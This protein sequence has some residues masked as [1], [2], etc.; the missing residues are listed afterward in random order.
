M[1][2][3]DA[4][5]PGDDEA[6]APLGRTLA[7]ARPA[8]GRMCLATLLGSGAV[9][10]SIGLIATAAWLISRASQHPPEASLAVAIVA[11]Q[12]FGLSRGFFRYGER[13]V[14]HDAAFH[15][16]A[17]LRVGIYRD[18]ES[19]APAGLPAF[20][21]GDLLARLVGD[22]DTLQDVVLRVIPPFAIAALVGGATVAFVWSLLPAAGAV[23]L[24]A[25]LLGCTV[26]P[27]AT[28]RKAR[29]SEARQAG[30]RGELGAASVDLIEGAAD[31]VV[32]GAMDA[33]VARIAS[34]DEQL[35]GMATRSAGTAG[36]GAALTM[37]LAGLAMW[38]A[39]LVGIP[40][41]HAGRLDGVLLAVITLVPLAAFELVAGIPPAMQSLERARGAA[42]RVF[43]VAD[44]PA[45]V[46]DPASPA[47]LPD[48]PYDLQTRGLGSS[49][50]GARAPALED[51]S[52]SLRPGSRVALV[53]PSGAGKTTLAHVVLRFLP[54]TGS[55]TLSGTELSALGGDDARRVV[56]MVGQDAHVF[57]TT[58]A[59]NL[60]I[61]RRDA[62]DEELARVVTAVGL[63]DWVGGLP[64]GLATDAGERGGRMSGGQ[65][66]RLAVAR[67]L[68][69]DFPILVL[70]EPT[71]HLDRNAA[72]A[73]GRDLVALTAGRSTLLITHRL[74]GL[75]DL[76]EVF[77]LDGGRVIEHG[78]HRELVAAGG[79]YAELW[80]EERQT[81]QSL[82]VR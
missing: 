61:G 26:V 29:R 49:Y 32:F 68:L 9:A 31:L 7:V 25:L 46:A 30:V 80:A 44:S 47:D 64:D 20:R 63:A 35:A 8:A 78:T 65:R 36:V 69:A 11:V 10:A 62:G 18:L 15:L 75:H 40:A 33:Q 45:P 57:A 43:A 19:L 24:V 48:A 2:R 5:V 52:L 82:P 23:L 76:D 70:D 22:V 27:A 72:D 58:L 74:S 67:A 4:R 77:V 59:E 42:A 38:G 55:A 81:G 12:F 3:G 53:G 66:Q 28:G 16:L 13:I 1:S 60:R 14:G 41:V 17:D 51:V 71:E 73:L 39:L 54:Y 6:R 50:P 34:L 37:L 56:G 21:S 79:R